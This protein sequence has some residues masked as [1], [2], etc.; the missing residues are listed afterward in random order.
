[1]FTHSTAHS[2]EISSEYEKDKAG[3]LN[4]WQ[5]WHRAHGAV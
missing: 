2:L 5:A 3:G 1:M 4:G